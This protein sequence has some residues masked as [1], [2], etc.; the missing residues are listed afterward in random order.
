MSW[1]MNDLIC[2][3]CGHQEYEAMYKRAAGPGDC[4]V[5]SK[6]MSVD[7]RGLRFA[8]HGQGYGSFTPVDFGSMGKAETKEDIEGDSQKQRQE[9][10]D[11]VRHRS[12]VEK[13]KKGFDAKMTKEYRA[14]QKVRKTEARAKKQGAAK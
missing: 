7:L 8:I 12:Y 14:E 6:A 1:M 11:G 5:C 13:K 2:K 4:V 3:D 10:L 9:R